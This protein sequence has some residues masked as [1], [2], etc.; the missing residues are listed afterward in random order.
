MSDIFNQ[1]ISLLGCTEPTLY[2]VH[3][4][5]MDDALCKYNMH[6]LCIIN[7]GL[8]MRSVRR[9]VAKSQLQPH[10]HN[11]GTWK[12]CSS[13]TQVTRDGND[14]AI[15]IWMVT[16]HVGNNEISPHNLKTDTKTTYSETKVRNKIY[17][18]IY[19]YFQIIFSFEKTHKQPFSFLTLK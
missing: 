9:A 5:C 2:G 10:R 7:C 19:V 3:V 15:V 12:Q 17:L 16:E 1:S 14:E 4:I 6:G 11:N 8:H 18:F 13:T